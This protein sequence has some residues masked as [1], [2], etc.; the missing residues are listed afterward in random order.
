MNRKS[1]SIRNAAYG[2]LSQGIIIIGQFTLQTIFIKNLS[3]SYLGANGLFTNLISFLSFAELGIGSAITFSL[4]KPLALS[5]YQ[6]V[7][8][9]MTLF[10]RVYQTIGLI[11]ILFGS[12]LS[13]FVNFFVKKGQ[14]VPHLQL[15]FVL[16]LL[17][18]AVSYFFT[19]TRSLLIANQDGYIDSVNKAV[20]NII[21]VC[22]QA[23]FLIFT[24]Q[25]IF[26]LIVNIVINLASNIS[27]TRLAYKKFEF[28][29]LNEAN[30]VP[31]PVLKIMKRNVVGT[32]SNKIGEIVVFGTD[33]VIISKF[34]G[35]TI[36]GIY[37]NY[38]LIINGLTSILNQ[39]FNAAISGFGNL[40]V[41]QSK[42]YQE[43]I[44]FDYLFIVS[45]ITYVISSTLFTL[46][47]PFIKF[48]FGSNL[49]F[50]KSIVFLFVVNFIFTELR[51][52]SL[53]FVA[54]LGIFWPMRI[55]SIVEAML[56]L[57]LSLLFI[58]KF[59]LGVE[60]VLLGTLGSTLLVNIWWEP[61][62]LFKYG[63]SNN[64]AKI[65]TKYAAK[66]ISYL[67]VIILTQIFI[68]KF[69]DFIKIYNLWVFIIY[70]VACCSIYAIIFILLFILTNEGQYA[71]NMIQRKIQH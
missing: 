2:F 68:F 49:T 46:V 63:F 1:L 32:V 64:L 70:G 28:L 48:W 56:N 42:K 52:A 37:S 26:Y 55:K 62:I 3:I 39:L 51:Q 44:F 65:S 47:Q 15:L 31:K 45:L 59:D 12:I 16:Y 23:F 13:F 11:I 50:S 69:G 25:Y 34:L 54:A 18:A 24:H 43:K 9:V 66:Y 27:I 29:N 22:I 20:F 7:N 30:S 21:Q 38:T 60:A 71:L 10:K 6:Q 53:G 19:Y 5:D 17:G 67:F 58:L 41:T 57:L 8:S 35:L 14:S 4:Y 36:S 33:N 40:G 61:F